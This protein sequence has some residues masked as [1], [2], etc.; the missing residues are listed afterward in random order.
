MTKKQYSKQDIEKIINEN[1]FLKKE[2]HAYKKVV[3]SRRFRAAEKIATVYNQILPKWTRRRS[4]VENT[5]RGLKKPFVVMHDRK[6]NK[7]NKRIEKIAKNYDKVMVINSIPWDDKLKQRPHHLAKEFKKLGFFVI[8]F[9]GSNYLQKYRVIEEGIIT[10]NSHVYFSG[11]PKTHKNAYFLL[12]NTMAIPLDVV[13][14]IKKNGFK[15]I[16]EY[17]DEFH[18]DISGDL[19][20]QLAIWD[21]LKNIKPVL[22]VASARSLMEELRKFLGKKQ[23][24]VLAPNAVF[25]EHFNYKNNK[26][27][28]PPSDLKEIVEAHRPIIGFYGALAPWID[29][30]LINN[31]AKKHKEWNIVLLGIDYNGAAKDLGKENNI[32]N[33][34][35]KQYEELSHYS[36]YFNCAMIPFKHGKI[37]KA[38]SPIKLFEYMAAGLPTVCTRDLRECRGYEYVFMAK[39]DIDF[40]RCLA[41]AIK[42]YSHDYVRERLLEQAEENTWEKRAKDI[43]AALKK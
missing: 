23:K 20:A 22:C 31:V 33:L 18:G 17:I 26:T 6:K 37:A 15:I 36:K 9:E 13:R 12:P 21:D 16:Y 2:N 34:G 29:F 28:N 3:S 32:Y 4:I 8:Y 1:K 11:I 5:Y 35:A 40:E 7:I 27:V 43:V 19:S 25:T 14:D 39:D 42:D 30:E 24:I 41:Q 10:V 38:T